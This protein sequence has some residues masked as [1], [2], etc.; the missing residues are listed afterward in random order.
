M[1]RKIKRLIQE[2]RSFHK[3][4]LRKLE[5]IEWANVYHDS[6]RGKVWLENLP[7]N[8]GRWAGNYP[9]FYFLHRILDEVNPQKI[10]E[11]G[12]GESTKMINAYVDHTQ[13]VSE[14]LI[15]EHNQ[16]W[17]NQFLIKNETNKVLDIRI[18]EL[19]KKEYDAKPYKSYKYLSDIIKDKKFDFYLIDGPFGST[20]YSRFDCMLCF[21][22][23]S[24]TDHF[25]ILLDD[26]HRRGEKETL[27][28][29]KLNF[30]NKEI[31]Y[32]SRSFSGVKTFT[33]IV[34]KDYEFILSL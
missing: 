30:D 22:N 4:T 27:N 14:Y 5:E 2:N 19:E 12:L 28:E 33:I 11:F 31:E 34:S 32:F 20:H 8:I 29:V 9:F 13:K 3:A 26:T 25:I 6:I 17:K 7:L 21:S 18:C 24:K 16:D 10:I 23:L 1:I 15:I